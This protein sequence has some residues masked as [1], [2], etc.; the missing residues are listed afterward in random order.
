MSRTSSITCMIVLSDHHAD[1]ICPTFGKNPLKHFQSRTIFTQLTVMN[2][3]VSL[4]EQFIQ[5]IPF[6]NFSL[7]F[8]LKVTSELQLMDLN[9]NLTTLSCRHARQGNPYKL[10]P[11]SPSPRHTRCSTS[12]GEEEGDEEGGGVECWVNSWDRLK[13]I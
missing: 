1:L 9:L 7:I 10:I 12:I 2:H 13:Q 8:W 6:R 11:D 4:S 5:P 3:S